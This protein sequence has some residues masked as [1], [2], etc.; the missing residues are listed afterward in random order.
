MS[1]HVGPLEELL[2]CHTVKDVR[3]LVRIT[4]KVRGLKDHVNQMP[5]QPQPRFW[6]T[7]FTYMHTFV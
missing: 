6:R 2:G 7:S 5:L 4:D 3:R 1:T